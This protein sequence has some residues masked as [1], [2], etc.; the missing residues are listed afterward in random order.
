MHSEKKCVN[1]RKCLSCSKPGHTAD[2]FNAEIFQC[3]NCKGPQQTYS[4][5]CTLIHQKTRENNKFILNILLGENLIKDPNDV[6]KRKKENQYSTH[7]KFE[8]EEH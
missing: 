4:D 8:G 5:K 2:N 3:L 6:I 1:E 7:Q